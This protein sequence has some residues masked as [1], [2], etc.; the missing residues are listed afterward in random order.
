MRQCQYIENNRQC[1]KEAEPG[2]NYCPAHDRT[3][4]KPMMKH[5]LKHYLLDKAEWRERL[6][7]LS[8]SDSI[9][10]LT[11]EI[12]LARMV[13]EKLMNHVKDEADLLGQVP[14]ITSLLSTIERLQKSGFNLEKSLSNLISKTALIR[15]ASE[16]G[17]ILAEELEGIPNY[18][19]TVDH[20]IDRILD[21]M[22]N[23]NNREDEIE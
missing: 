8:S 15:I 19:Q 14:K 3:S 2:T 23:A 9:K 6:V 21:T 11:E 10:T 13:L 20:I 17:E 12:S 16:I 7:G 4:K 18:E 22:A 1:K 5:E